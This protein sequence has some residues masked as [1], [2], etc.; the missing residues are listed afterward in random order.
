IE[1]D[2]ARFIQCLINVFKNAIEHQTAMNK[3]WIEVLL[4]KDTLIIRNN[5]NLAKGISPNDIFHK[6][7]SSKESSGEGLYFV[8]RELNRLGFEIN[9]VIDKGVCFHLKKKEI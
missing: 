8:K 2:A 9:I 1:T 6:G 5:G 4:V 7:M 3:R